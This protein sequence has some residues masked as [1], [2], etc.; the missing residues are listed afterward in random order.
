[1]YNDASSPVVTNCVFLLNSATKCGG[2]IYNNSY[3]SPVLMNCTFSK[4]SAA[5]GGGMYNYTSTTPALTN[6]I[7]WGDTATTEP[8]I[9]NYASSAVPVV[10]FSCVQGGYAGTEN[11]GD[12]PLFVNAAGGNL[13]LQA[14][15]SPCID[16]GTDAGAPA[17]DILGKMR[18]QG[19]GAD[20]GAYE[21]A[22]DTVPPVITLV[23]SSQATA[24]C[25]GAYTDAGAP[26]SVPASMHGDTQA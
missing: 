21:T 15:V 11:I 20:M 22:A 18:P 13:Q 8:E 26:A 23:G 7:L 1:M 16:A 3:S 10:A 5:S 12:N 19:A 14:C 4:N 24:E 25:N 9:C 6:C 2:A 17:A